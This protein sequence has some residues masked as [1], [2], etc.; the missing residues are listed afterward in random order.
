M[1]EKAETV[2]P[3]SRPCKRARPPETGTEHKSG[4]PGA[5]LPVALQVVEIVGTQ[6]L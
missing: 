3:R 1:G 6:I 2:L 4:V 5:N